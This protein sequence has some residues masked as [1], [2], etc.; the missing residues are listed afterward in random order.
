M[1]KLLLSLFIAFLLVSLFSCNK[2]AAEIEPTPKEL[3]YDIERIKIDMSVSSSMKE[4]YNPEPWEQ[5]Q[6]DIMEGKINRDECVHRMKKILASYGITHLNLNDLSLGN[7]PMRNPFWFCCFGDDYYV[8]GATKKYAK[9]LGWKVKS[10]GGYSIEEV[11]KKAR[12]VTAYE[13]PTGL[14]YALERVVVYKDFEELGLTEKGK[15]QFAFESPEGTVES[16]KVKPV[17]NNKEKWEVCKK[18]S[19]LPFCFDNNNY[20]SYGMRV[21]PENKTI[22]IPFNAVFPREDYPVSAFFED[23]V[24]EFNTGA[25][26]TIVFDLRNNSGGYRYLMES[27]LW[28]N[29]DALEKYNIAL[30][31]GGRTYSAATEF[32]DK[33]LEYYPHAKLFG[34]ETGEAVFNYTAVQENYV[35]KKLNIRF[36]WPGIIDEVPELYARSNDIHRGTF[37]DVEVGETFEGYMKGE[38]SI[39]K[40]IYEY[41]KEE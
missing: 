40:A 11:N 23:I 17:Y 37:P 39:Y 19:G 31:I 20:L 8:L 36:C 25:Y 5:L 34:E 22:Y 30:V 28:K 26:N 41:Y 9:Y 7:N 18:E 4:L 12:E 2:N 27:E 21:V 29:K 14:K 13:T 6:A 38:D 10:I 15:I 24:K 1:K 35:L 33:V 16:V 3:Y 32:V